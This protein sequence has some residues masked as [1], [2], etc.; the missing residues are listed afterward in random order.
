MSSTENKK[1]MNSVLKVFL[2]LLVAL[3]IV[4]LSA[5]ATV[6]FYFNSKLNKIEYSNLT[7]S[8]LD[9]DTDIDNS[10]S[11]SRN[12]AIL[13]IDARSDTFSPGNCKYQ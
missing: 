4:V 1:K 3:L 12:I 2:I 7:K 9:I 11:D 6:F 10:L 13:G 5:I 8:D